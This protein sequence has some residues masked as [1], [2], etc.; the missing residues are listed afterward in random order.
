MKL[1][2]AMPLEIPIDVSAPLDTEPV[3]IDLDDAIEIALENRVELKRAEDEMQEAKRR[4]RVAKHNFCPSS[5]SSWTMPVQASPR[6]LA[7]L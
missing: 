5:M 6:T 1:V 7:Q 3:T 4:S 2:L